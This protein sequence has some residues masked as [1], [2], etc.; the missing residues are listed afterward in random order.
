MPRFSWA[1][2]VGPTTAVF[3][4]GSFARNSCR[5]VEIDRCRF[6]QEGLDMLGPY[7]RAVS[8]TGFT[9]IELLVALAI[10]GILISLLLPAV[11]SAR[12]SARRLTCTN[13]LR[14]LGLALHIYHDSH[15]CFPP[16]SLVM[17]PSF[18]T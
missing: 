16:G 10:V 2:F 15:R 7:E 12:A 17:G 6:W 18:P 14:Q 9:L 4:C 13:Q 3:G 5:R 1:L 8:R 11:Q